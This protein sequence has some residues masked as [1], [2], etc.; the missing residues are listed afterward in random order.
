MLSIHD[1]GRAKGNSFT[2]VRVGCLNV[3][4][5]RTCCTQIVY[6]LFCKLFDRVLFYP[7]DYGTDKRN[8]FLTFPLPNQDCH[9]K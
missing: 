9:K 1:T 7:K 2:F 5:V 4:Q 6:T 8:L 3:V